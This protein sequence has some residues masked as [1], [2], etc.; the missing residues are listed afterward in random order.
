MSEINTV[1]NKSSKQLFTLA[2]TL[3]NNTSL[4]DK[5][6]ESLLV[7]HNVEPSFKKKVKQ[8]FSRHP[9]RISSESDVSI[10]LLKN[11]YSQS[12]LL[13]DFNQGCDISV[14]QSEHSVLSNNIIRKS[15]LPKIICLPYNESFCSESEINLESEKMNLPEM[16]SVQNI[17]FKRMQQNQKPN[18]FKLKSHDNCSK[19]RLTTI[20]TFTK[21]NA[22]KPEAPNLKSAHQTKATD[23]KLRSYIQ[24]TLGCI[25]EI[26][27][28]MATGIDPPDGAEDW[29]RARTRTIE[30]SARFSRNYLYQLGR[31]MNELQEMAK[32]VGSVSNRTAKSILQHLLSAH[33]IILQALQAYRT[34]MSTLLANA[35]AERLHYIVEQTILLCSIHIRY[36]N[37]GHLGSAKRENLL[38]NLARRC[39]VLIERIQEV[40]EKRGQISNSVYSA[41]TR[42]T[43][44][45]YKV[46]AKK[47]AKTKP[48]KKSALEM[49]LSM[50]SIPPDVRTKDIFWK[51]TVEAL[52]KDKLKYNHVQSRYK[53][54]GFKHRPVLEKPTVIELPAKSKLFGKRSSC[55]LRN[56]PIHTPKNE[57]EIITMVEMQKD[58]ETNNTN[59]IKQGI[60]TNKSEQ[61]CE[62]QANVIKDMQLQ[63]LT[64]VIQNL[65][66]QVCPDDEAMTQK[67]LEILL[68]GLLGMA[69]NGKI[70]NISNSNNDDKATG[71]KKNCFMQSNE[72]ADE[73]V[74]KVLENIQKIACKLDVNENLSVPTKNGESVHLNGE[75]LESQIG[76]A[77]KKDDVNLE[78]KKSLTRKSSLDAEKFKQNKDNIKNCNITE[79]T[80]K[81]YKVSSEEVAARKQTKADNGNQSNNKSK[82]K[83]R[84]TITGITGTKNA[85]LICV[86]DEDS[87]IESSEATDKSNSITTKK[88]N[89]V[90]PSSTPQETPIKQQTL[91]EVDEAQASSQKKSG[92]SSEM[93]KATTKKILSKVKN[94]TDDKST[95]AN[96]RINRVP[97]K[98]LKQLVLIPK[99]QAFNVI[100]YKLQYGKFSRGNHMYRKS[101]K[102][103]PWDVVN[104]ISEHLLNDLLLTIAREIQVDQILENLYQSEFQ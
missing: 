41:N 84:Q 30:F 21:V 48:H 11:G 18:A 49:R 69:L 15:N 28:T 1:L 38:D 52:A 100:Q 104:I 72:T 22:P 31:E 32:G 8:K 65:C 59:N 39:N 12:S 55:L 3:K 80:T 83:R 4:Q 46:N 44:M 10:H 77:D 26:R 60:S 51:K 47:S 90:L 62:H 57:D 85:Q 23:M 78:E 66:K 74:H 81:E 98:T 61:D 25:E 71:S 94:K 79:T 7:S 93:Q 75:V 102:R 86:R 2:K 14:T 16:E 50:Y 88:N 91:T 64:P 53:T 45:G 95:K 9:G 92:E 56:T 29:E 82:P 36:L 58:K 24:R 13:Y 40:M 27:M 34:H 73:I 97:K 87:I 67:Q 99:T 103:H 5:I 89:E 37:I 76:V 43:L 96:I 35:L 20:K 70:N 63:A 54:A 17:P 101:S 19:I 6:V 42:L 33:Q 68:K